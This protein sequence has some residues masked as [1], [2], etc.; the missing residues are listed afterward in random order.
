L[1][2]IDAEIAAKR[3][4]VETL[5]EQINALAKARAVLA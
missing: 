1:K 2:A 4:D 5:E 3:R